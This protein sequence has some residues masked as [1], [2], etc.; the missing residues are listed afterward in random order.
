M[1]LLLL[2]VLRKFGKI[3]LFNVTAVI[4]SNHWFFEDMEMH[5]G[6]QV[7]ISDAFSLFR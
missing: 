3:T 1:G 5:E 6:G 4:I 7:E 2:L